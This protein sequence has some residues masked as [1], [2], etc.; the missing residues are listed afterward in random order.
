MS[1]KRQRRKKAPPPPPP[2]Q[3]GW[4]KGLR[5]LLLVEAGAIVLILLYLRITG[6]EEGA[7]A[8]LATIVMMLVSTLAL[9]TS[10]AA[11]GPKK[12]RRLQ[13]GWIGAGLIGGTAIIAY[14][15]TLIIGMGGSTAALGI[16][17][18]PFYHWGLIGLMLLGVAITDWTKK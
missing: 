5:N 10:Y 18:L 4:L 9:L 14:L 16:I 8:W 2:T 15:V 17:V 6:F 12:Q 1:K 3:P 13:Y 7:D 11:S